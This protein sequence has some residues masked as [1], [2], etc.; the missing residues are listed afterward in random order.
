MKDEVF[1][2][3]FDYK[4]KHYQLKVKADLPIGPEP[5]GADYDIYLDRK[6]KYTINECRNEDEV[7]CW[8]VKKKPRDDDDPEFAQAIGK[9][10]NKHYS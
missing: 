1:D 7:N 9:A 5:F 8:E 10:I 6:H 3:E 2:I 4:G